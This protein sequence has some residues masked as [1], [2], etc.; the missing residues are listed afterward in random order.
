MLGAR[1][2]HE[3]R[4]RTDITLP[5]LILIPGH[6]ASHE[7]KCLTLGNLRMSEPTSLAASPRFLY[8]ALMKTTL[9]LQ[10]EL[11]ARAKSRA[12][13]ERTTLTRMV[14]EGLVL[15]LRRERAVKAAALSALPV[16]KARG[17]LRPGID[18][19]SNRSMLDAADGA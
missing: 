11:L 5:P 10:D 1:D 13:Q 3:R 16:S 15:R 6:S 4:V 14:E 12:A 9:D 2:L 7:Q 18:G 17:G 8:D 19:S